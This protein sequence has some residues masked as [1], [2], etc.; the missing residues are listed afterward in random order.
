MTRN[1]TLKQPQ[2][3]NLRPVSDT[4]ALC[5]GSGSFT[6]VHRQ[7]PSRSL[8]FLHTVISDLE[9]SERQL[10][11]L[12]RSGHNSFFVPVNGLLQLSA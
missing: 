6:A 7:G 2:L 10:A 4:Q 5:N 9:N 8:L 12:K 1:V 3:A 11:K